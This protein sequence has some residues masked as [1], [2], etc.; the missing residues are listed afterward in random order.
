MAHI[1]VGSGFLRAVGPGEHFPVHARSGGGHRRGHDRID[2]S[3]RHE[4]R[5]ALL[6]PFAHPQRPDIV[7]RRYQ[8]AGFEESAD[9]LAI[10]VR[11]RAQLLL[12]VG[13]GLGQAEAEFDRHVGLGERQLD[14]HDFR[15]GRAENLEGRLNQAPGLVVHLVEIEIGRLAETQTRNAVVHARGVVRHRQI[16]AARIARIVSGEHAQHVG[17]VLDRA[18]ERT[19]MVERPAQRGDAGT[20]DPPVG[21]FQPDQAAER[22]GNADRPAGIGA[23]AGKAAARGNA[24]PRAAA[25]AA[26]NMIGV[27]GVA[28]GRS[29]NAKGELV[30]V[31]LA[32]DHGSGILQPGHDRRIR[33]RLVVM[34][35]LRA[36]RCGEARHVADVLHANRDSVHRPANPARGDFLPG[37]GCGFERQLPGDGDIGVERPLGLAYPGKAALG[38]L[39]RRNI[40]GPQPRRRLGHGQVMKAHG[41]RSVLRLLKANDGGVSPR[42]TAFRLSSAE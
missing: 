12:V 38:E 10:E 11:A 7:G 6:D 28:R 18:G 19:Y 40:P 2:A 21:R 30:G 29:R 34:A 37:R 15:A 20:A 39:N 3:R 14:R 26:R 41:A 1:G 36:R 13:A 16:D 23:D 42:S 9:I 33:V 4:G 5:P 22:R 27:P 32:D 17:R 25:G 31:G 8:F 24:R 35:H